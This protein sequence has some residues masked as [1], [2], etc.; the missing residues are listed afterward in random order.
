VPETQYQNTALGAWLSGQ[1][2]ESKAPDIQPLLEVLPLNSEQRHAVLHGLNNPLTVITGPPGTGKSQVVTS[3]LMNAAWQGKTVLFAS[4]NNKA[5]D[6]VEARINSL[7]PRPILLRLGTNEFQSRLAEYLISLLAASASE[8][9][10]RKYREY[11]ALHD[12][13]RRRFQ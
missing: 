13:V 6:V 7:G 8:D 12:K 2:I 3:L 11:L 9:D 5:V 10:E 4:K 1:T